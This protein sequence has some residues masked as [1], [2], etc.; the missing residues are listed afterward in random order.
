MGTHHTKKYKGIWG[1]QIA[2]L[3]VILGICEVLVRTDTVSSL[4]LPAPSQVFKELFALFVEGEIWR[5]LYVTLT[6]FIVG[7]GISAVGGLAI[8]MALVLIPWAEQFFRPYLSALM[9]IPKVTVV[10]LLAL[11]LGIGM[12]HKISIVFLFCFFTITVN[13]MAGIKQ[14]ADNHLKVARV[15]EATR[16]QTIMKVILP[17]AAPTI[18]AALRITAATGL[19]GAL[20]GEMLASK[21]GLGNI[22]V[23]ATS[24]YNTAQAFAIVALVTVVSVLIISLIDILERNVF[25]KWKSS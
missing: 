7:Y 4:Y 9:A 14:T 10:P 12:T 11:W 24:L 3:L 13:T 1:W 2:L 22:L 23:K 18:F 8:G 21:D 5:H 16:A 15:F 6:E 19:V 25:L 20:F 17:S